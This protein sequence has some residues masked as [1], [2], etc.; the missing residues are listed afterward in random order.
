[1]FTETNRRQYPNV[2]SDALL[3]VH[4]ARELAHAKMGDAAEGI[5]QQPVC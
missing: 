4:K 3:F 2:T 1:M 5:G